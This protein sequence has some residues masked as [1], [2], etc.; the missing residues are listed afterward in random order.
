MS[1]GPF[2]H[3]QMSFLPTLWGKMG[4]TSMLLTAE[5]LQCSV[6]IIEFL[7]AKHLSVCVGGCA[8]VAYRVPTLHN[9]QRYMLHQPKGAPS[10]IEG[11]TFCFLKL[12]P[13]LH[14]SKGRGF[15]PHGQLSDQHDM[16]KDRNL[17]SVYFNALFDCRISQSYQLN[18]CWSKAHQERLQSI[19]YIILE[20][21]WWLKYYWFKYLDN[22]WSGILS[23][24]FIFLQKLLPRCPWTSISPISCSG[25]A[26]QQSTAD[27]V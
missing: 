25:G 11:Q 13:P 22:R 4:K 12:K 3:F 18:T 21:R 14:Y 17:S 6:E 10:R 23:N 27:C 15:S 8:P 9:W 2:A 20:V 5:R 16:M 7:F 1:P 24:I 26:A 19:L